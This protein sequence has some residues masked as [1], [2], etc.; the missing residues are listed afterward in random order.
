MVICVVVLASGVYRAG[1]LEFCIGTVLI[2]LTLRVENHMKTFTFTSQNERCL[3]ATQGIRI[4]NEDQ[5]YINSPL[6]PLLSSSPALSSSSTFS[7][8]H[9]HSGLFHLPSFLDKATDFTCYHK[10][11][12]GIIVLR[13]I[14]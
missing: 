13:M 1:V 9:C 10:W 5:G 3:F 7:F 4:Q 11:I 6:S 14:D 2:I 8:L 12:E